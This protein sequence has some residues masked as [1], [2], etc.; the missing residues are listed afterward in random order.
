MISVIVPTWNEED[1]LTETLTAVEKSKAAR[2]VLVVD[3]GSTDRTREIARASGAVIHLSPRRQ[4]A[5]QMNLGAANAS[6]ETLLF[7]H[8]DTLLP[9]GALDRIERACRDESIVGGGFARRF[10]SPSLF[11]RC[12]CALAEIRNR[13]IGWHLGDQAIFVRKTLFAKLGGFRG[14]DQ[15]EDLDFSR[16]LRREGRLVTLRPPVISSSRRFEREGPVVRTV[17]DFILTMRYLRRADAACGR[18]N[19]EPEQR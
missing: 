17:R 4:R 14:M 5:A 10:Q 7:L 13:A 12:T 6:G 18:M 19:I 3:A 15:F 11:L 1:Q 2:E 8:A 9:S 16:R